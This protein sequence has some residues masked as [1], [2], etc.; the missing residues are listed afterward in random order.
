M[1]VSLYW[2]ILFLFVGLCGL[3]HSFLAQANRQLFQLIVSHAGF[4]SLFGLQARAVDSHCPQIGQAQS[5]GDPD[6][7]HKSMLDIIFIA[8]PEGCD[9]VVIW[10]VGSCCRICQCR[11]HERA[12]AGVEDTTVDILKC[13]PGAASRCRG[14]R[15]GPE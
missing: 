15:G 3:F 7:R 6:G 11:G 12:A 4:P 13:R 14:L 9:D 5:L 10:M 2:C 8:K 1:R